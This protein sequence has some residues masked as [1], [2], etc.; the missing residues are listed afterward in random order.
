M[1]DR[2][3]E[4]NTQRAT[5]MTLKHDEP[6]R[7]GA[8]IHRWER[9]LTWMAHPDERMRRA[10]HALAIDDEVW[11]VDPLDA[12]RLDEELATLGTVTGVVVLTNSH[13]RHADR[14]AR[15][16]DVAIHVPAS[17]DED[18]EPVRSFDAPVEFF[19]EELADTGFELVWEKDGRGWKEGALYHAGRRT[20]VVPD[21]LVTALFTKEE[22]R[23][24]VLP[25]FRLSP[26]CD[27]L[28]GLTV[29]RILV[30]H[31]EPVVEN[32]QGALDEA[33]SGARRGA[34][35]AIIARGVPTF[36]R[37]AYNEVRG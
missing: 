28:G 20:L 30:G 3:P 37:I 33:L 16:H 7:E 2:T 11:L 18:A 32:A 24:E 15:H 19:E 34:I 13:G 14:L 5:I 10:S 9:G 31:G 26:P 6:G 29:D 22:G 8:V 35:P 12:E 36:A 1:A 25:F 23:L 27:S 4:Q 21:A 17:F